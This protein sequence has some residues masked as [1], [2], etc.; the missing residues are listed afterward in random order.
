M[1]EN[2]N[3]WRNQHWM[4]EIFEPLGDTAL[5]TA[6]ALLKWTEAEKKTVL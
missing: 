4:P 3:I 5:K 1:L 6:K 2:H